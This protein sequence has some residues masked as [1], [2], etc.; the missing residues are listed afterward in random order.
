[1]VEKVT[2]EEGVMAYFKKAF[3]WLDKLA[4][5]ETKAAL[6]ERV[7]EFLE[8]KLIDAY[9]VQLV[10]SDANVLKEGSKAGFNLNA[11]IRDLG[12]SKRMRMDEADN[13]RRQE[14]QGTPVAEQVENTATSRDVA[15]LVVERAVIQSDYVRETLVDA[16][17]VGLNLLV[18]DPV[19][20]QKGR[21]E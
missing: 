6:M 11:I 16:L 13:I 18:P 4:D 2:P 17:T 15:Q 8:D 19:A 10:P 1:M 20:W 14:R 9:D 21:S 12:S 3:E 7:F 5:D